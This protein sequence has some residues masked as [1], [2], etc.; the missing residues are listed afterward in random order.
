MKSITIRK[1]TELDIPEIVDIWYEASVQA[2][3]FIPTSYWEANKELMK[4]TYI[5]MS[6]TY[7]ANNGKVAMGFISLIDDYLAAIFVKPEY[8]GNGAGS[9]L[10]RYAMEHHKSLQVKVYC[11]NIKSVEFYTWKGF[12]IVS[13]SKDENT[14]ENEF[15]MQWYK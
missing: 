7:L 1:I 6:E 14:G 9:L 15:V 2:H 8:Q 3:D 5:K 11:K 12:S 4:S 13:E 10:I